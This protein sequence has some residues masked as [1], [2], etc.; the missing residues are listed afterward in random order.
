M[1]IRPVSELT[2]YRYRYVIGYVLIALFIVGLLFWN[3]HLLPPGL[4]QAEEASALTSS[5][6]TM[7]INLENPFEGVLQFLQITNAIDLPYHLL[8][9][10]S[11]NFFGLSPLGVRLPSLSLATMSALLFL[12][13]LKRWLPGNI[14]VVMSILVATSSWFLSI[15]RIG[16]PEIMIIFWSVLLLLLA[17][18]ISQESK[19]AHAW[20]A[21]A[22]FAVGLSLYSPYIVYLFLAIFIASTTQPHIRY[23]IRS[24][25]TFSVTTALFLVAI[26]LVPLGFH[27]V[28]E[29]SA[30]LDLL[31]LP[32]AIPGPFEFLQNLL[33]AGSAL[34]NPFK[35]TIAQSPL[36]LIGIPTTIL[37]MIGM[38]QL[39]KDWHAVRSH[40][41]LLWLAILTP[42]LALGGAG[43]SLTILFVPIMLLTAIGI[44]SLFKYW[45]TIFPRNPY[46][47][48]FG[49]VPLSILV[50]SMINFNYQRYF[51]ATP[52]TPQSAALYNQDAF[53]L[54]NLISSKTYREQRLL[55]VASSEK[56]ELYSID[57]RIVK[58][59]EVV[60]TA[61]FMATNNATSI[62]VVEDELGRLAPTQRVLLPSGKT[63]LL[64]NDRKENSLRFR[65]FSQQ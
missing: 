32:M 38:V 22:L 10:A 19:Y 21:F 7:N 49:L 15:G 20:K 42:I 9:K 24:I 47:R 31:A 13:L 62:I 44:Q 3:V 4:S 63:E 1:N 16:T 57:K 39:V 40:T 60:P 41:L 33:S 8:Q 6:I 25:E 65:V 45:Y 12:I 53:I 14:A 34:V 52:Y 36:P 54:H 11:L 56:A 64:V 37:A 2:L 17:T 50:L 27:I 35:N 30:L 18:L 5:R 59:L 26:I 28:R 61:Q 23:V 58:N 48:V 51:V 29:P 46:A 55:I 43:Q